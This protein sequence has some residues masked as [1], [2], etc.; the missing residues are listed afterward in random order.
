MKEG[1]PWLCV[2]TRAEH[3]GSPNSAFTTNRLASD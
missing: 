2:C 1:H 3:E